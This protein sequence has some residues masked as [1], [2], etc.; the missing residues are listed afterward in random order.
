MRL[1]AD[2]RS[3][4]RAGSTGAGARSARRPARAGARGAAP[5]QAA[6]T[7]RPA[8]S[9]RVRGRSR[10]R[11]GRRNRA[12]ARRI[13]VVAADGLAGGH[14][15]PAHVLL[16]R[17][18]GRRDPDPALAQLGRRR[19]AGARSGSRRGWRRSARSPACRATGSSGPCR[20]P[21]PSAGAPGLRCR[22]RSRPAPAPCAATAR[23]RPGPGPTQSRARA[24]AL[25]GS[26][27]DVSDALP[28]GC[29]RMVSVTVW[30][31]C[32]DSVSASS[33]P[34]MYGWSMADTV[35]GRPVGRVQAELA[36]AAAAV[37]ARSPA[38]TLST[39]RKRE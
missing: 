18:S 9:A 10:V 28:A 3:P 1:P 25:R 38:I 35:G 30:P 4:G 12:R 8:R 5:R 26:T 13:V 33:V 27:P 7:V 29:I 36:A 2:A 15:V 32:S 22:G 24:S 16:L 34:A 19:R 21:T 23:W 14:V 11:R 20:T 39:R 37:G 31:T 6:A 17:D